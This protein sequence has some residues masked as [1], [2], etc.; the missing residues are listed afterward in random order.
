ME[1]TSEMGFFRVAVELLKPN[2][3]AADSNQIWAAF[4][5][6]W[7]GHKVNPG[8]SMDC[9]SDNRKTPKPTVPEKPCPKILDYHLLEL[10]GFSVV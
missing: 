3:V 2:K 8:F 5:G 7:G 9:L 6:S 10:K 4:P 1:V